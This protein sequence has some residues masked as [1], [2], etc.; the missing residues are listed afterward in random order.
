MLYVIYNI[1]YS[2]LYLVFKRALFNIFCF[3]RINF[4]KQAE[5]LSFK[6]PVSKQIVV[7]L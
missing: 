6:D 3:G 5:N 1:E 2:F 4:W 7:Y